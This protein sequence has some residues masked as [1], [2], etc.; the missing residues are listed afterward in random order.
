M[1]YKVTLY[2]ENLPEVARYNRETKQDALDLL[3]SLFLDY[4]IDAKSDFKIP[5]DEQAN[6]PDVTCWSKGTTDIT[7]NF[8]IDLNFGK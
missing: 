1:I 3:E 2:D 8:T 4:E 5:S 7:C 6:I